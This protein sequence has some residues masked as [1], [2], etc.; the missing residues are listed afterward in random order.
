MGASFFEFADQVSSM[1]RLMGP[2]PE[3][4]VLVKQSRGWV[5][6]ESNLELMPKDEVLKSQVASESEQRDETAEEQF[7]HP[8]GYPLAGSS[9]LGFVLDGHLPPYNLR[10]GP[11]SI[12]VL[13][14]YVAGIAG[15]IVI[16]HG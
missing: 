6:P 12:A 5:V 13:V 16:D 3:D 10:L 11:D 15:L 14:L 1:A 7:E 4:A 8:A 9:P 2:D